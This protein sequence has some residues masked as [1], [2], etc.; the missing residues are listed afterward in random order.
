VVWI[1]D[2][3]Q[4]GFS[5][6]TLGK[7]SLLS[8]VFLPLSAI[9]ICILTTIATRLEMR[10]WGANDAIDQGLRTESCEPRAWPTR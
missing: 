9:E 10:D 2:G 3:W 1:S 4:F 8:R 6:F 5:V 7:T